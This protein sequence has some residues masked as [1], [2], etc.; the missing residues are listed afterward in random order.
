MMHKNLLSLRSKPYLDGT[1][2]S[3][4]YALPTKYFSFP[5][6]IGHNVEGKVII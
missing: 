6:V 5:V 3:L 2:N 1:M 4:H